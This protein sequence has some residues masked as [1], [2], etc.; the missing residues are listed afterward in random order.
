MSF[1]ANVIVKQG[2]KPQILGVFES[3]LLS[4]KKNNAE[5]EIQSKIMKTLFDKKIFLFITVKI[6]LKYIFSQIFINS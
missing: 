2:R 3:I 4:S 1:L 5:K 6:F